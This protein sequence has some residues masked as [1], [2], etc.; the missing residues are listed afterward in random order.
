MEQMVAKIL[1]TRRAIVVFVAIAGVLLAASGIVVFVNYGRLAPLIVL[2]FDALHGVDTF[3]TRASIWGVWF[4]G[5]TM[6]LVNLALAYEFYHRERLLSYLYLGG[7]VLIS[8]IMFI[9]VGVVVSI[10]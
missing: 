10:N 9:A 6:N 4:L 8:L 7:N 2:H 1:G 5:L 3:G